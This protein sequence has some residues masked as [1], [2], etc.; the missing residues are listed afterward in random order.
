MRYALVG[1]GF[2]SVLLAACSNDPPSCKERL[3]GVW[4]SAET[5]D[6]DFGDDKPRRNLSFVT[7]VDLR[8]DGS[9]EF[10]EFQYE[11]PDKPGER[12]DNTPASFSTSQGW[13]AAPA[14]DLT[15][16]DCRWVWTEEVEPATPNDH[17][18][19]WKDIKF[20]G[21]DRFTELG[22]NPL[23]FDRVPPDNV[24]KP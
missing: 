5:G 14:A 2:M 8:E 3:T 7:I 24:P 15:K 20:S 13:S 9:L 12:A 21:P 6:W 18:D 11:P 19:D 17:E 10:L 23:V 22:G 1:F 4:R 16:A